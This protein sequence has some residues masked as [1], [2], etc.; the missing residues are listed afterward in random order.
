MSNGIAE[1]WDELGEAG[2]RILEVAKLF[3]KYV[4]PPDKLGS[5]DAYQITN[6]VALDY[7]GRSLV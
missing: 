7:G 1:Y 6:V 4:T 5:K 3:R 2:E